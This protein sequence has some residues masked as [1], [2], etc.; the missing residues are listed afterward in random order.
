MAYFHLEGYS[1]KKGEDE[2]KNFRQPPE[3]MQLITPESVRNLIEESIQVAEDI[4][5]RHALADPNAVK[6][7]TLTILD[8]EFQQLYGAMPSRD[9]LFILNEGVDAALAQREK[10]ELEEL[11]RLFVA[12]VA[13]PTNQF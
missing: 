2:F 3:A 8:L 7:A 1:G 9:A 4:A 13:T 12:T 5:E 10:Q 11:M 6:T